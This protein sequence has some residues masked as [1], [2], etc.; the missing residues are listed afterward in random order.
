MVADQGGGVA[1]DFVGDPAAA[2]HGSGL[3]CQVSGLSKGS[4]VE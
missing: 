3:R 1:V 2:G 4:N